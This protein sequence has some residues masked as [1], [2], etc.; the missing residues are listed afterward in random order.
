MNNVTISAECAHWMCSACAF[1]DCACVCHRLVAPVTREE[2]ELPYSGM[3]NVGF[4]NRFNT[5]ISKR[6]DAL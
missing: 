5:I 3:G 6:K 2:I 4:A 1:E